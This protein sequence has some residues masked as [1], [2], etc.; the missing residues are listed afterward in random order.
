VKREVHSDNENLNWTVRLVWTPTAIRPIGPKQIYEGHVGTGIDQTL[1]LDAF[2]RGDVSLG[3]GGTPTGYGI[4]VLPLSVLVFLV[5][6]IPVM[7]VVLPLRYA[8]VLPWTIEAITYPWGK[9]G[10]PPDVLWWRVKGR[11]GELERVVDEIAAALG[12]GE[13]APVVAG[14]VRVRNR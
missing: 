12:R 6:V 9:H 3:R 11:H 2:S 8:R 13:T 10:G 7:L 4:V 14:A 5:F 1:P